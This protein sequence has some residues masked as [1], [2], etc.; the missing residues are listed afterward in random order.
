MCK[1]LYQAVQSVL[2]VFNLTIFL[3]GGNLIEGY[4]YNLFAGPLQMGD[5][6]TIRLELLPT[7]LNRAIITC[8]S[9]C[10][11]TFSL[12]IFPKVWI[13]NIIFKYISIV[14]I[15]IR[16]SFNYKFQQKAFV[17]LI[18]ASAQHIQTNLLQDKSESHF[19][20]LGN[21]DAYFE[22]FYYVGNELQLI[23]TNT[24]VPWCIIF[25]N[26]TFDVSHFEVGKFRDF[27]NITL[28][29]DN[30]SFNYFPLTSS[31]I[32]I[33]SIQEICIS[34]VLFSIES[35]NVSFTIDTV[36][37]V[38]IEVLSFSTLSR[39][40]LSIRG[41]VIGDFKIQ[42]CVFNESGTTMLLFIYVWLSDSVILQNC[43][44]EEITVP[45]FELGTLG[46]LE[47]SNCEFQ[48][49]RDQALVISQIWNATMKYTSFVNSKTT[50][51]SITE[52]DHLFIKNTTF[53]NNNSPLS[54]GGAIKCEESNITI[55]KSTFKGN[56]AF[57]GGAMNIGSQCQVIVKDSKFLQ[58]DARS[59]GT[60]YIGAGGSLN[61]IN[62]IIESPFNTNI[63]T[64]ASVIENSGKN[65]SFINSEV[66]IF[67]K[68]QTIGIFT[69]GVN[70]TFNFKFSCSAGH[71][72]NVL[73]NNIL[74]K[75]DRCLNG[76]YSFD[77]NT[78]TMVNES[79]II[80]KD[81]ISCKKCPYGG[82][83][84]KAK[85]TSQQNFW[86]F[87][88]NSEAVFVQCPADYCCGANYKQ[89][90][91]RDISTCNKNRKG[92][93][94][95]ECEKDFYVNFFTNDCIP[96]HQCNQI[97]EFWFSF[98]IIGIVVFLIA[99]YLFDI[100]KYLKDK[101]TFC[102]KTS[103]T[104]SIEHL[105]VDEDTSSGDS[106]CDSLSTSG[107]SKMI[108]KMKYLTASNITG[109]FKISVNFYQMDLLITVQNQNKHNNLSFL[110]QF[111]PTLLNL[112]ITFTNFSS[113]F[114]PMENL[115]AV[116]KLFIKDA[117]FILYL[118]SIAIVGII[119]S[120]A[121]KL[122]KS[123]KQTGSSIE[124]DL[125]R[126]PDDQTTFGVRCKMF[127]LRVLMVG[128][129]NIATF[130]LALISCVSIKEQSRLLL[131]GEIQCYQWFQYI[132]VI[133]L[134]IWVIPFSINIFASS[135]LLQLQSINVNTFF[136]CLLFPP[137]TIHHYLR[138]LGFFGQHHGEY[139]EIDKEYE[140]ILDIIQDPFRSNKQQRIILWDG[141]ILF[142]RFVIALLATFIYNPI[143]RLC[144]VS[145][146]MLLFYHHHNIT[147]P[148]KSYSF[149]S[150]ESIC[151]LILSFLACINL[152]WAFFD[153]YG[154]TYGKPVAV[155]GDV[156]VVMES[157]LKIL[158]FVL[159]FLFACYYLL[160]KLIVAIWKRFSR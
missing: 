152:Y 2:P 143:I 89:T 19:K 42:N 126:A 41:S 25:R 153:V 104:E 86:G 87:V 142:R 59:G 145:P 22:N 91:C 30:I 156:F 157:I 115:D 13:Q 74:W 36:N 51:L 101:L 4:E 6:Q 128:Y 20:Y 3:D 38:I 14:Q 122:I 76:E 58:N 108:T 105:I 106:L 137:V 35:S 77:K 123:Y 55:E 119:I 110:R 73:G 149:N 37:V 99:I 79:H 5:T 140:A 67:E 23:S 155:I 17:I 62:T 44:F 109:V 134:I 60:F 18:N 66:I 15:W 56:T 1:T 8:T 118:I 88:H 52:V 45:L 49:C 61:V 63:S 160:S 82:I 92:V 32:K 68:S 131:N 96:N 84:E 139:V 31:Y 136:L 130:S 50:S 80:E 124:S 141:V 112:K 53:L 147:L 138:Y 46:N 85:I 47:I 93:I 65:I 127:I 150:L 94:C 10:T 97:F 120:K 78:L 95:G 12:N 111:L 90:A 116:K 132:V 11:A 71:K 114:C 125:N 69:T 151:F 27:M 48:H 9:N 98:H 28:N 39:G 16:P 107:N 81:T 57:Q 29:M 40:Q 100:G 24:G 64:F 72:A 146:I 102:K 54:L 33:A 7:S 154:L 75:C 159:M 43:K 113:S 144:M 133:F 135:R 117:L 83:C 121:I 70:E 148:Y 129:T 21:I 103:R 158:P 26:S 34:N